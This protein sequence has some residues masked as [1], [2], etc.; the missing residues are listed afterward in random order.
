MACSKKESKG[1]LCGFRKVRKGDRGEMRSKRRLRARSV[2]V[3]WAFTLKVFFEATWGLAP[4]QRM[5][6]FNQDLI[7]NTNTN[8]IYFQVSFYFYPSSFQKKI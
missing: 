5:I 6:A 7:M 3:L 2:T 8:N 4:M 1:D